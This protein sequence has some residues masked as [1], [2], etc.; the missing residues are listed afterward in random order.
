MADKY[1]SLNNK[2]SYEKSLFIINFLADYGIKNLSFSER[3]YLIHY[4]HE[5]IMKNS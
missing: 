5:F 4:L 3:S 2:I 1:A